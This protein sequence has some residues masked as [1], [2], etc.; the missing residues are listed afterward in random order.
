MSPATT[1][2][3]TD[4]NKN[5]DD[6]Y[7]AKTLAD[8]PTPAFVINRFAFSR[9]C[10]RLLDA[11]K[12]GK[13]CLRP[14]IKTHKALE[15]VEWQE[16][17]TEGR[18][19]RRRSSQSQQQQES[20]SSKDVADT[21]DNKTLIVRGFVASTIPEVKLLVNYLTSSHKAHSAS[22]S[23]QS[24]LFGLPISETKLPTLNILQER[25]QRNH[26]NSNM[27]P[28]IHILMDHVEQIKMVERFC[29]ANNNDETASSRRNSWTVF[30][31]LDTGYHRA[32]VPCEDAG[33]Y[34]QAMALVTAIVQSPFLQLVGFY[35]HWYVLY[36][37]FAFL[38]LSVQDHFSV[39]SSKSF[40]LF[41][42][43]SVDPDD[44]CLSPYTLTV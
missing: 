3:I 36:C 4:N 21:D 30:V 39:L 5:D 1:T 28:T 40:Y 29:Q 7:I 31:K 13:F 11:A 37:I 19:R 34:A 24:I 12:Q 2:T 18:Y 44:A 33:G 32:G 22:T 25:L 20:S 6:D 41:L 26:D 27:A 17:G 8:L 16:Y 38:E 9:N 14:H 43:T 10:Q 23:Q 42:D 15:G 35:S